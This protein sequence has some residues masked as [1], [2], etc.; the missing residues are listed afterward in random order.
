MLM[1]FIQ[2][3][4]RLKVS[5]YMEKIPLQPA[6][7]YNPV[8]KQKKNEGG[9]YGGFKKPSSRRKRQNLKLLAIINV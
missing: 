9:K 3:N 2:R 4:H 5:K 7:I 8:I 6:D 1:A